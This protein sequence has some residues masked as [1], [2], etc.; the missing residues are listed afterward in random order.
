MDGELSL[1][2][3]YWNALETAARMELSSIAFP[4]IGYPDCD[5]PLDICTRSALSTCSMW[6]RQHPHTALRISLT[7]AND[8]EF[9][10]YSRSARELYSG[11]TTEDSSFQSS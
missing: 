3:C 8:E 9:Q 11:I 4:L 7:A 2:A 6:L 1:T 5:Y 10:A